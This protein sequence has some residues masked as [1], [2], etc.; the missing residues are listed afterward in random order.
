M[1]FLLYDVYDIDNCIVIYRDN[2]WISKTMVV[3]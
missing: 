2:Q 3:S 1:H